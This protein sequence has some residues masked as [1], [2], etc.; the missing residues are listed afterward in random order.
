MWLF[1][2]YGCD[3]TWREVCPDIHNPYGGAT[4]TLAE[5]CAASGAC[6]ATTPTAAARCWEANR[7]DYGCSGYSELGY[8]CV[9]YWCAAM[10]PGGEPAICAQLM[11]AG[12]SVMGSTGRCVDP[13]TRAAVGQRSLCNIELAVTDNGAFCT[14]WLS[15]GYHCGTTWR[16]VCPGISNPQGDAMALSEACEARCAQGSEHHYADPACPLHRQCTLDAT[17]VCR[18]PLYPLKI[19]GQSAAHS[20]P[21]Y[22]CTV[23]QGSSA[24]TEVA[25]ELLQSNFCTVDA[26]CV[27]RDPLYPLR[28]AGQA[29]D[30]S[31]C[32]SCTVAQAT[33]GIC[34]CHEC[35]NVVGFSRPQMNGLYTIDSSRPMNGLPTFWL[36][37]TRVMYWCSKHNR[38]MIGDAGLFSDPNRIGPDACYGFAQGDRPQR[39]LVSTTWREYICLADRLTLAVSFRMCIGLDA[40]LYTDGSWSS[41][42]SAAVG[43]FGAPPTLAPCN[44]AAWPNVDVL[45]GACKALINSMDNTGPYGGLCSNFCDQQGL[46]CVGQQE[47]TD[48]TCDPEW[49]GSCDAAGKQHGASTSDLICECAARATAAL[50]TTVSGCFCKVTWD[51]H[52]SI[53]MGSDVSYN[54]C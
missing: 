20:A 5:G 23:A 52:N 42:P 18:D 16:E 30:H 32:Y 2:G 4:I 45:C 6:G 43:C 37:T 46:R 35:V 29:A 39:D 9:G 1:T 28:I 19:E 44:A 53:C 26:T 8:T 27:C 47:D 10:D 49:T 24:S 34:D 33:T 54:G 41:A 21:C 14:S 31:A 51:A 25:C 15:N 38:W 13:E 40:L 36:A 11:P 50:D 7:Q 17:C 3:T 22:S 12:W 48:N